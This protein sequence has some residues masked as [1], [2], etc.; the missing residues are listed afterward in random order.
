MA[1]NPVLPV[2]T[3][4]DGS[5]FMGGQCLSDG[6]KAN[7]K[8]LGGCDAVDD[9]TCYRHRLMQPGTS[10]EFRSSDISNTCRH[11]ISAKGSTITVEVVKFIV[12]IALSFSRKQ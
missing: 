7:V 1:I 2:L 8:L 6:D 3:K 4:A 5:Q 12:S 10:T 9:G 11:L